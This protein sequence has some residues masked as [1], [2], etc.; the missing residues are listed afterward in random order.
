MV[1]P[2]TTICK[3]AFISVVTNSAGHRTCPLLS[4]TSVEASGRWITLGTVM[5]AATFMGTVVRFPGICSIL[6]G[7]SVG[8][9]VNVSGH[10]HRQD[11]FGGDQY[12][13]GLIGLDDMTLEMNLAIQR[14]I[15]ALHCD[16]RFAP[17]PAYALDRAGSRSGLPGSVK[18]EFARTKPRVIIAG[19][20]RAG[21]TI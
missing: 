5:P 13:A 1:P 12:D 6:F 3:P 10:H 7:L 11:E 21:T 9:R 14:A 18:T 8:R 15:C 17:L 16:Q 19:T 2:V 4:G 20:K